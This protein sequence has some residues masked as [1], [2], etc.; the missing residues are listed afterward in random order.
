MTF[1]KTTRTIFPPLFGY[2]TYFLCDRVYEKYFPARSS[3]ESS[4]P[5]MVSL[6]EFVFLII[7]IIIVFTFQ[8]KVIVPRTYKS[9]RKTILL[10]ALLGF[11]FS[12]LL[13]FLHYYLDKPNFIDVI[14]TFFRFFV[15]IESFILGNLILITIFNKLR[16]HT[17]FEQHPSK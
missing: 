1:S 17:H 7:W 6:L 8:Y 13:G 5:G 14:I 4:T 11:L 9:T 15:E 3:N 16:G 12:L 10:T 2:L